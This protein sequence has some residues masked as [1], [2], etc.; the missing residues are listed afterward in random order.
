[1]I[2]ANTQPTLAKRRLYQLQDAR[3]LGAPPIDPLRV[4]TFH[5]LQLVLGV[6]HGTALEWLREHG[7][8]DCMVGGQHR[9]LGSQIANALH[10]MEDLR[11]H[12]PN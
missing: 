5:E 6:S 2:W 8:Q 7:L 4:Y 3:R 11:R 9:L 1:M 12:E 10:E